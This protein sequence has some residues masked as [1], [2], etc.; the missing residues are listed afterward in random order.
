MT[1]Y[2]QTRCCNWPTTTDSYG[3]NNLFKNNRKLWHK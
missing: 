3:T 1:L 2:K